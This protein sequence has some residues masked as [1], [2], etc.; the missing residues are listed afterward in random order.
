MFSDEYCTIKEHTAKKARVKTKLSKY[1]EN[2][3]REQEKKINTNHTK[4]E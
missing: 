4:G 3:F 1:V 2:V